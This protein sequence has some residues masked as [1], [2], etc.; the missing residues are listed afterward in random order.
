MSKTE[1]IWRLAKPNSVIQKMFSKKLGIS[2]TLAQILINRNITTIEDARAFIKK[3]IAY[4]HNPFLFEA[5]EESVELI[6]KY[7]NNK[8]K[9]LIFGDYDV[10]G[11]TSTSLL[12][13][14]L[15]RLGAEVTYHIPDRKK[16]G[17]GL[18]IDAL[19]SHVDNG[20]KLVLTVD[21]GISSLNEAK[22][23]QEQKVDLIIT[24]HH[25]QP[26]ELPC[27]KAIL[28]PKLLGSEY[29]FQNLAGVGVAFKLVQALLSRKYPERPI[30]DLGQE[31]LDIVAIGTVAD[32]VPLVGEN[33]IIVAH[34]LKLI[35]QRTRL[36]VKALAD[37]CGLGE[38]E[39][40]AGHIGFGLAP[41]LNA[42]GRLSN[43]AQG[44]ELIIADSEIKAK[45]LAIRLNEENVERQSVESQ[46][47]EE[48]LEYIENNYD[49]E[50][51]KVIVLAS[52]RWHSGVIGIV[53][54]R[55]VDKYY[56][57]TILL[58]VDDQIAKG[59]CR[60][61]KG[62]DMFAALTACK[63][64]LLKFGGHKQAAGLSLNRDLINEFREKVNFYADGCLKKE[65][66]IPEVR[67][68]GELT[69]Q[70]ISEELVG[71]METLEPFGFKNPGPLLTCRN[72]RIV[73]MRGVGKEAEH[74][75][76]R[77]QSEHYVLDGIAFKM[78]EQ[79]DY[80]NC[81]EPFDF[82][83]S[84]ERNEFRGKVSLQLNI[85]DFKASKRIDNPFTDCQETL[86]FVEDLFS[87]AEECLVDDY[88]RNIGDK[89][90]FYTKVVGVSFEGRQEIIKDM[91]EG[92][93]LQLKREPANLYDSFAIRI[94]TETG[95][96][97]G[98]LNAK[99]AKH[100]AP[101]LDAG[102]IYNVLITGV[103][104][105]QDKNYGLNII[106]QKVT[107]AY[108]EKKR[109]ELLEL[110]NSLSSL[111]SEELD[112]KIQSAIIGSNPYRP[113]QW[114]AIQTLVEGENTLAI[115]GTGRG[116]SAVFQTMAA[117]L[118]LK[119]NRTTIIIYPLRALVNDQ[120][121]SMENKLSR[122]GLKVFKANG[123]ISDLE[124]LQFFK[125]LEKQEVD[126]VLTTPEFIEYHLEK[127]HI[128]KEKIGFFVVDE[129]HHI[130]DISRPAY[131]RLNQLLNRLG[132]P[133][134]L[135]VT[136]TADES[137]T[138]LI[139]DTLN[140]SKVIVDPYI[141]ENLAII[142]K[143][144]LVDKNGYIKQVVKSGEKT[145]IYVNSRSK[146]IEL[147]NYLRTEIPDLKE[148]VI[149]YNAGLTSDDRV[150]V[151][152]MFRNGQ[153]Q[154]VVS[155]SAFGE[156][157]D[158]PDVKHVVVYHLNFNFTEFNQQSGRAGRDGS[159]AA[160]HLLCGKRDVRINEFILDSTTPDRNTLAKLYLLLKKLAGSE[161]TIQK[162]NNE[163]ASLL[164]KEIS[165]EIMENT[166]SS[167]LGILVDLELIEREFEGRERTI[168]LLP[169]PKIKRDL[170]ESLKFKEG[171]Q[172]KHEFQQ[173]RE[174]LFKA[175]SDEL[176][177]LINRP[178]YPEKYNN[179]L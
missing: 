124:R 133:L 6:F 88:Y 10:D 151:E 32:I 72:T 28:N 105:G 64:L 38:R 150:K 58:A 51:N 164:S 24:D 66:L 19:K 83:F 175:N 73:E 52:E 22:F 48:V 142:D 16:E 138:N 176:L 14:V 80:L 63:D 144:D 132:K 33:R 15:K 69:F 171:M 98:Y 46:I 147:A 9:I 84:I 89:E 170:E 60:S 140:I 25:E 177:K 81:A 8:E 129:S 49:L 174:F 120:F 92:Q 27:A 18:S 117:N 85:R 31:Y 35:N 87:R 43:A 111:S 74:L 119:K 3:D 115:F 97:I 94:E 100:L 114:E 21:C 112:S 149:F 37:I 145:I 61:I 157:I 45:E 109:Q 86:S 123:S 99:L 62:F 165:R 29:P 118:A 41:R 90:E 131:K 70:E 47:T 102:V 127:F 159:K 134:T 106:L 152:D 77:L 95:L 125:A 2:P 30:H 155:T 172:E 107:E 42:A 168:I 103:T 162:T 122:L 39:I 54:S 161:K 158:I 75:K 79:I 160:I 156:G 7:I 126:I 55:I 166:I 135:A 71:E 4:L 34:G 56:R 167:G 13:L 12:L 179:L 91:R 108:Q 57:P 26:S 53:A 113:K 20:I 148:K 67:L 59:S 154:T 141:R 78:G 23:L 110:R 169:N 5:M 173:F 93:E 50:K 1:K 65:D 11:I 121:T 128:L 36:G 104:G 143:R 130:G 139:I 17:Y 146:T 40:T 44:V 82:A 101:I 153:V 68:D 116:K 178:I 163:L 96:Q 137:T 76:C 136:A